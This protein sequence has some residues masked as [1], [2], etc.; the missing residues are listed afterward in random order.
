MRPSWWAMPMT[1]TRVGISR[2]V[3]RPP[4]PVAK[5]PVV[6]LTTAIVADRSRRVKQRRSHGV[7]AALRLVPAG[8]APGAG[9]VRVE[10]GLR[11]GLAPDG[12]V[13][14]VDERVVGD[15]VVLDV[16]GDVV[17]GPHRDRVDLDQP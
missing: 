15:V 5:R 17:V 13:A 7:Q 16:A 2:S 9:V 8:P 14:L 3:R 4:V 10:G 6:S 12:E 11:A 1:R